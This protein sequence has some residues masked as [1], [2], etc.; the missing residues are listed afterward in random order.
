MH[1]AP[2]YKPDIK[3]YARY[4]TDAQRVAVAFWS[5]PAHPW[6]RA[7]PFGDASASLLPASSTFQSIVPHAAIYFVGNAELIEN[8]VVG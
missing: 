6:S 7:S 5:V 4:K 3:L 1:M 2:R 8:E